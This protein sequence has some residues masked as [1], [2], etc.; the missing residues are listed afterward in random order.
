ME[1]YHVWV[2]P[3]IG[4]PSLHSSYLNRGAAELVINELKATGDYRDVWVHV[5]YEQ[6]D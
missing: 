1:I 3:N 6:I 2:F 5:E 4:V